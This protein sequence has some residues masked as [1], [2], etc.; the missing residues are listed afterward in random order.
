MQPSRPDG[1]HVNHPQQWAPFAHRAHQLQSRHVI[2]TPVNACNHDLGGFGL[3]GFN[4]YFVI[5]HDCR[6]DTF[7]FEGGGRRLARLVLQ[8]ARSSSLRLI[9]GILL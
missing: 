3:T 4:R 8:S 9:V 5:I 6:L 7:L 2:L 1:S